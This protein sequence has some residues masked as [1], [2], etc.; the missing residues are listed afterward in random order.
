MN[1]DSNITGINVTLSNIRSHV[2]QITSE[3]KD[4]LQAGSIYHGYKDP[5]ATPALNYSIIDQKEYLTALPIVLKFL[6]PGQGVYRP[7]YGKILTD[8]NICN[9]VNN[10]GLREVWLYGWHYGNIEPAES[11]MSGPHGD[12]SN[13]GGGVKYASLF[14]IICSLQL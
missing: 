11:V 14:K 4:A 13:S 12:T 2:D 1:L 5:T 3:T 7:D 10:Q 9:Y 6:K 8:L